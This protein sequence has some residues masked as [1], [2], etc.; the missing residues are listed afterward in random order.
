MGS[1]DTPVAMTRPSAYDPD[2]AS[3]LAMYSIGEMPGYEYI[4][5]PNTRAPHQGQ[6]QAPTVFDAVRMAR[7]LGVTVAVATP[8]RR[9]DRRQAPLVPVPTEAPRPR[10]VP[11]SL[12]FVERVDRRSITPVQ[13]RVPSTTIPGTEVADTTLRPNLRAALRQSSQPLTASQRSVLDRIMAREAAARSRGLLT[14]LPEGILAAIA[15]RESRLDPTATNASGDAGAFQINVVNTIGRR[16]SIA[17]D[18]RF[19][20]TASAD[21]AARRLSRGI[22]RDPTHPLAGA[23]TEYGEPATP[24]GTVRPYDYYQELAI[25]AIARNLVAQTRVSGR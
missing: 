19:D 23:L 9:R 8:P 14:G 3:Y 1:S 7:K 21:W 24:R 6:S 10:S 11:R 2:I 16:P 25:M 18:R 5:G 4:V 17:A 13:T 12:R 20:L 15:Y 22:D